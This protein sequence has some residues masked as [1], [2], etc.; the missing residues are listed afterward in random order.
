MEIE[1]PVPH[2]WFCIRRGAGRLLLP[3][4]APK[5]TPGLRASVEFGPCPTAKRQARSSSL[6]ASRNARIPETSSSFSRSKERPSTT[7][8][9]AQHGASS[10]KKLY[11]PPHGP[12]HPLVFSRPR[13]S[14][15]SLSPP[16]R[17]PSRQDT[18]TPHPPQC[19]HLL[20]RLEPFPSGLLS[21]AARPGRERPARPARALPQRQI[22]FM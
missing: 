3:C 6:S 10:N 19:Q 2:G 20:Q 5:Y 14:P 18:G 4:H 12:S 17:T 11:R 9:S 15:G 1:L 22:L 21:A 7:F 13:F 16:S 8:T